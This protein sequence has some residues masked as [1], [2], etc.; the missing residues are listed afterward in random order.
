[1]REWEFEEGTRVD[2]QARPGK[3][4]WSDAVMVA[5]PNRGHAWR[6]AREILAQLEYA[7]D[8]NVV[9]MLFGKLEGP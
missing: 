8:D 7:E 6:I 1:M 5:I 2:V 3:P 9:V 4:E